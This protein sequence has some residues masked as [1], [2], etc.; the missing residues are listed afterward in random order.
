[1]CNVAAIIFFAVYL[2]DPSANDV[3]FYISLLLVLGVLHTLEVLLTLGRTIRPARARDPSVSRK[4]L[5]IT[6]IWVA[7]KYSAMSWA[8]QELAETA[9]DLPAAFTLRFYATRD[10]Q[11]DLDPINPFLN[12]GPNHNLHGGRPNWEVILMYFLN[13]AHATTDGGDSV[14][15]FFCGSPVIARAI[16]H[17]AHRITARHQ[18]SMKKEKQRCKCAIIVYEENF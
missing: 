15:V 3:P 17:A 14:G 16:R 4:V 6:G 8:A 9:S 7:R 13:H 18:Y 11:E 5:S 10:R 1:V 2:H 12:Y